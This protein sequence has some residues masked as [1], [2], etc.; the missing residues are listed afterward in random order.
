ML[1]VVNAGA[2]FFIAKGMCSST[3]V[4]FRFKHRHIQTGIGEFACAGEPCNSAA[5][6][7]N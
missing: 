3:Q 6:D 7:C 1:T 5:Y 2:G 4:L